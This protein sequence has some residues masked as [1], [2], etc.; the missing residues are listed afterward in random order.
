[1]LARCGALSGFVDAEHKRCEYH[2]ATVRIAIGDRS[3]RRPIRM[4]LNR[5]DPCRYEPRSRSLL[6]RG[7]GEIQA[8]LLMTV[9]RNRF[10]GFH[11]LKG[12]IR[13]R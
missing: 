2:L 12:E 11:D 8:Q 6:S 9:H 4:R 10:G 13:F 5:S 1:M 3:G 7:I